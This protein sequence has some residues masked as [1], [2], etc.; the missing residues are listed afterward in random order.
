M[1]CFGQIDRNRSC[2]DSPMIY[3]ALTE[4]EFAA[5]AA[6]DGTKKQLSTTPA[7]QARLS[8][9]LLTERRE[10]PNG[11]LW[12]T[13]LGDRYVRRGHVAIS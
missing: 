7:I 8:L 3:A 4:A 1:F 13:A 12:R 6:V 11:T 10:W 5:L 2:Y 9:L